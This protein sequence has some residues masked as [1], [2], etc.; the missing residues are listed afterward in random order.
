MDIIVSITL[1]IMEIISLPLI[2][3]KK[4]NLI[5]D[6]F[7]F[8]HNFL[9]FQLQKIFLQSKGSDKKIEKIRM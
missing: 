8:M 9:L 1:F 4:H 3:C 2:N 5:K 6:R 7:K